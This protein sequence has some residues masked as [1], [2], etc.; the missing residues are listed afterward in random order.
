MIFTKEEIENGYIENDFGELR[1]LFVNSAESYGYHIYEGCD[2][3][4][5][6]RNFI[7]LFRDESYISTGIKLDPTGKSIKLTLPTTTQPL[8]TEG[9]VQTKT[10]QQLAEELQDN[11][12]VTTEGKMLVECVVT[13]KD[14]EFT[15]LERLQE[16]VMLCSQIINFKV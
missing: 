12:I 4:W 1:D 16:Y 15:S 6:D 7:Y 8:A 9:V 11:I 10:V 5:L 13:G 14:L 3:S 2:V